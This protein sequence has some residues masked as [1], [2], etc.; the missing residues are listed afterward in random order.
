MLDK[1]KNL[2]DKQKMIIVG[3]ILAI[4]LVS[5]YFIYN[6]IYNNPNQDIVIETNE[7]SE[8]E[9]S[10]NETGNKTYYGS[11]S[12][13]IIVIDIQGEVNNPRSL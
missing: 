9:I 10:L 6:F 4:V 2:T 3:I 1:L 12:K 7:N 13:E 5:F 8:E 11:T